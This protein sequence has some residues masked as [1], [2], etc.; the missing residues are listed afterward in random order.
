M[1]NGLS[2]RPARFHPK[3]HR[4]CEGWVR[5]LYGARREFRSRYGSGGGFQPDGMEEISQI[6]GNALIEAIE[7]GALVASEFV[8]AGKG[9][10][11]TGRER[12]VDPLE[13][14]Q[15]DQAD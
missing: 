5:P 8:I 2:R 1:A 6:V 13:Q 9:F 15:E 7:F 3:T 11:E 14:F 4:S 12:G 10:E